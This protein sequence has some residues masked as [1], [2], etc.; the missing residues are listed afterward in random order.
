MKA[1]SA[2]PSA[3]RGATGRAQHDRRLAEPGQE[4]REVVRGEVPHHAD[5]TAVRAE[6][7][8]AR[9]D[10]VEVA[11]RPVVDQPLHR[12]HRGAVE[13]RVPAHEHASGPIGPLD[14]LVREHVRGSQ[15]L[16]HE[17]VLG[18]G[19]A[20]RRELEVGEDRGRDYDGVHAGVPEHVLDAGRGAGGR[21]APVEANQSLPIAIADPLD[22][23]CGVVGE[24]AQQ[25]RAPIA[26]AD[27]ADAE[28]AGADRCAQTGSSPSLLSSATIS[29]AVAHSRA[30]ASTSA[31][32]R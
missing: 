12:T 17:R 7:D 31:R 24:D 6:V 2:M 3:K 16:L 14:Q 10:E 28:R 5:V 4:D 18:S 32:L 1:T 23:H 22:V 19:E 11:E 26:Q 8:P 9:G 21:V 30:A 15:R 25:V 29:T 27:H 13:E 20:R